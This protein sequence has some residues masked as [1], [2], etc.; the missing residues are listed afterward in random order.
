MY[1]VPLPN[2]DFYAQYNSVVDGKLDLE[3]IS[4][5]TDLKASIKYRYAEYEQSKK[6]LEAVPEVSRTAG[7]AKALLS[8]YSPSLKQRLLSELRDRLPKRIT[9]L[10]KT[11]DETIRCP[12]CQL[13]PAGRWDHFLP[14][15]RFPDFAMYSPN[16]IYVCEPCNSGIKKDDLVSPIR[17]TVN[18]YYDA[19][20]STSLLECVVSVVKV[21][22]ER[23]LL[24]N[25]AINNKAG[26]CAYLVPLAIRHF[27]A[28][29][30]EAKFISVSAEEL[31]GLINDYHFM[32]GLR[33]RHLTQVELDAWV[34]SKRSSIRT[35]YPSQNYWK[36]A[37]W[38]GIQAC[39]DLLAYLMERCDRARARPPLP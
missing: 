3:Y 14:S 38:V 20:D 29:G 10:A 39:S 36:N 1:N 9:E 18:P 35:L 37:L 22:D 21:N 24:L 28:Y 13:E 19:L 34:E 2:G 12:Y 8:C 4:A 16:L 5:L 26:G 25:F 11:V 15:G 33:G 27:C 30:L 17:S 32:F 31:V 7:E 23:K 6:N